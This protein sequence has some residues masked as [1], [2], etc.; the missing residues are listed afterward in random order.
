MKKITK[1]IFDDN[2]IEKLEYFLE[3][4]CQ[5]IKCSECPYNTPDYSNYPITKCFATVVGE[6]LRRGGY[7]ND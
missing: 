1:I 7:K 5:G 2:E 6:V 4:Q 3:I